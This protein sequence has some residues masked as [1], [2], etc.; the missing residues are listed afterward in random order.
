MVVNI[1]VTEG[2]AIPAATI[3]DLENQRISF[4]RRTKYRLDIIDRRLEIMH[5]RAEYA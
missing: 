4:A 2:T 3:G 1:H 5:F